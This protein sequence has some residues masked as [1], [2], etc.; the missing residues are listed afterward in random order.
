MTRLE[1]PADLLELFAA[2]A[3]KT[4]LPGAMRLPFTATEAILPFWRTFR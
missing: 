1:I 4:P 2:D 3:M